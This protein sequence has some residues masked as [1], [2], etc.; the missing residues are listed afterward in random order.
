MPVPSV[1]GRYRIRQRLGSGAFATVWLADDE[2]LD[3]LV[4]VK[5]LAENW[6]DHLDVRDRFTQEA[7][8]MR[9][10]DSDRLI[11]VFDVGEL[12]DGRPYLV[13]TY[14]PGGNLHDKPQKT[15]KDAITTA[16]DIAEG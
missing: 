12:P 1:I 10:A 2:A 7:Q 11:R 3:S 15:I 14:A 5:V 6:S 8:I 9:R 13:M 4:A 16:I